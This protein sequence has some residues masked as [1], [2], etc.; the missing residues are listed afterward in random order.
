V[1]FKVTSALE[2]FAWSKVCAKKHRTSRVAPPVHNNPETD[3]KSFTKV[4]STNRPGL[5]I[6]WMQKHDV[7][8]LLGTELNPEDT[9][10]NPTPVD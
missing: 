3:K 6:S 10:I 7:H 5:A 9:I 2:I 4:D 8:T 1:C